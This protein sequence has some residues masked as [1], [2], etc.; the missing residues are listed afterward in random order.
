MPPVQIQLALGADVP[1]CLASG[2]VRMQGIGEDVTPVTEIAGKPMILVNPGV[3]VS[4]PM[5]FKTL[6]SKENAAISPQT[7][8]G[9]KW[10]AAQ[11]NDLQT[12]AVATEPVIADVLTAIANT[13]ADLARMS[14]S[15]ATCFGIYDT[16]AD[17]ASAA[18]G[19]AA[20]QPEW[21][22]QTTRL[23]T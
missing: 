4:T 6:Q 16:D 19:I 2:V 23:T 15:G 9:W 18:K 17:A 22:V 3:S 1:V 14:G 10:I 5:I 12:P 11:R 13:G 7:D 8:D 20:A 21:W